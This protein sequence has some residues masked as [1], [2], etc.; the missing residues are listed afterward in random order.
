M[1]KIL[2]DSAKVE[3]P[4]THPFFFPKPESLDSLRE[5]YGTADTARQPGIAKRFTEVIAEIRIGKICKKTSWER[6]SG[7]L[8]SIQKNL[9]PKKQ[10]S[11]LDVGAS[12]GIATHEATTFL[13]QCFPNVDVHT[14]MMDLY[15]NLVR[16]HGL[17]YSIYRT[18]NEQPVLLKV[19]PLGF[20]IGEGIRTRNPLNRFASW[21]ILNW[22]WM[23]NGLRKGKTI[24]LINPIASSDTRIESLE[25]D[26][27]VPNP[28]LM[29]R[30]NLVRASNILNPSYF[31]NELL[32]LAINNLKKYLC[33][34]GLFII[35]RNGDDGENGTVW[36]I[37]NNVLHKIEDI[38]QGSL[39]SELVS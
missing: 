36:R 3:T 4:A 13:Q 35:S 23:Q 27:M 22:Q 11:F 5:Q 32:S 29:G 18:T 2:I 25:W 12:D 39:I 31:S 20:R 16:H 37:Q 8:E 28:D 19:G 17:L 24:S 6:L 26:M 33:D 1:T 15:S 14:T 7:T 21:L 9:E 10:V 38:G 34:D 30:F